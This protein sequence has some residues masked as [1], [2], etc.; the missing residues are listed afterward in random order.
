MAQIKRISHAFFSKLDVNRAG[1]IGGAEG[2][3]P[4]FDRNTSKT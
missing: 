1:R 4:I 3:T 2:A